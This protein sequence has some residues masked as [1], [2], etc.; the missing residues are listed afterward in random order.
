MKNNPIIHSQSD[1]KKF[2]PIIGDLNPKKTLLIHSCC[3][4]CSSTV[5]E[6]LSD[7]FENLMNYLEIKK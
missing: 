5:L 7:F 3:G 6:R 4:P 2:L 1:S